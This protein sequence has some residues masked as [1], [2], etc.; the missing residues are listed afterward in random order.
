MADLVN[1][2]GEKIDQA[3]RLAGCT[4]ILRATADKLEEPGYYGG[5]P[6]EKVL[7]ITAFEDGAQSLTFSHGLTLAEMLWMLERE[8]HSLMTRSGLD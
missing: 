2:K 4:E 3:P 7:I 6:A 1:I 5:V 8:R